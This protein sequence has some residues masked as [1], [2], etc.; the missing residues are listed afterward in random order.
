MTKGA[1]DFNAEL[2]DFLARRGVNVQDFAKAITNSPV[3]TG[4]S[5]VMVT[6]PQQNK[7]DAINRRIGK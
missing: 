4:I 7:R 1:V 3:A 5:N 6:D 2:A